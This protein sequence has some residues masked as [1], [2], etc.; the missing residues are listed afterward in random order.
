MLSNLIRNQRSDLDKIYLYTKNPF[1]SKYQSL[2]KWR[3]KVRIKE[4]KNPKT[5]IDYSQTIGDVYENLED[6]SN[7]EKKV[8]TV[9]DVMIV[10]IKTNKKLSTIVTDIFLRGRKLKISLVFILKSYFQ[11]PKTISKRHTLFYHKNTY[12]KRTPTNSIEWFV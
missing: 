3:E 4:L 7:K 6:L 1:K 5:F 10:G 8:L 12:Q 11:V 2:I 9:F